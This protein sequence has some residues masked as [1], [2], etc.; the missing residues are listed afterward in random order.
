VKICD[1][2]HVAASDQ[3]FPPILR[4]P[5]PS[6]QAIADRPGTTAALLRN[7][8]LTTHATI[9]NTDNMP[10]PQLTDDQVGV[11]VASFSACG[12]ATE[13]GIGGHFRHRFDGSQSRR[14]RFVEG[15]GWIVAV[16]A[17]DQAEAILEGTV[18]TIVEPGR[19][20]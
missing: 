17:I 2:C 13:A 7:F 3:Q 9:T 18:G 14:C 8:L 19:F 12:N 6:F 20:G 1:A 15:T 16:G 4:P 5:A 11:L 10:N